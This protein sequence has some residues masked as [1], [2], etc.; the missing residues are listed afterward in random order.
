VTKQPN[1]ARLTDLRS[2]LSTL[3]D[4]EWRDQLVMVEQLRSIYPHSIRGFRLDPYFQ[5]QILYFNCFAFAFQLIRWT[6]FFEYR[7]SPVVIFD[8]S[9][10][11]VLLA[12][13]SEKTDADVTDGDL[14]I[15]FTDT[16]TE[17]I[18][19][20]GLV[21]GSLV[22][23][24]WGTGHV[25]EHGTFEVPAQHGSMV[26]YFA[27]LPLELTVGRFQ[28]HA[29]HQIQDATEKMERARQWRK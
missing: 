28:V 7:K 11:N 6:G 23:S 12:G 17:T 4:Q 20:A 2:Q 13:A 14:V 24:K 25:W 3:I 29:E 21:F 19:H 9:L 26:R 1:D 22:R 16:E 10:V 18:T 27:P 8:H 15:Y 5:D